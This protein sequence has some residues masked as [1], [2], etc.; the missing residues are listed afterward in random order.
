MISSLEIR[1]VS[2]ADGLGGP[3]GSIVSPAMAR[4]ARTGRGR[5][6]GHA[7]KDSPGTWEILTFGG[8]QS[9]QGTAVNSLQALRE[10]AHPRSEGTNQEMRTASISAREDRSRE[11]GHQEVGVA[12]ST[13]EAGKAADPRRA[14]GGKGR[15]EKTPVGGKDG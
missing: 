12:H 13:R 10:P 4:T 5:R 7:C 3:E 11:D 15:P 6:T 2:R 1:L 9:A 14:C 8:K